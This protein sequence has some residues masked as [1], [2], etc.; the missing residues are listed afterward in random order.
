MRRVGEV[1]FTTTI[2]YPSPS[3][4]PKKWQ[5]LKTHQSN[6]FNPLYRYT[7]KSYSRC[8]NTKMQ[9][10]IKIF[11]HK[12]WIGKG[13]G[14]RP[15]PG[16]ITR[17]GYWT[18]TF[19]SFLL[20]AESRS[21]MIRSIFKTQNAHFSMSPD[22]WAILATPRLT[23][24]FRCYVLVARTPNAFQVALTKLLGGP[25]ADNRG[26][27]S[28]LWSMIPDHTDPVSEHEFLRDRGSTPLTSSE[29]GA[30]RARARY[31]LGG[32]HARII[33]PCVLR[34]GIELHLHMACTE[35]LEAVILIL[36]FRHLWR[37]HRYLL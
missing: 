9:S 11:G 10:K 8:W 2:N 32:T 12:F 30:R 26:I 21:Q 37:K 4:R 31:R 14:G 16:P 23:K 28:R 34:S 17:M 27:T 18:K 13:E 19:F 36:I 5:A 3:Q 7:N 29:H 25:A 35:E 20:R 1:W 6:E 22:M 33:A 24:E 15:F